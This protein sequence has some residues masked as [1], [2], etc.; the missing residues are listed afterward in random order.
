MAGSPQEARDGSG[1]GER[2]TDPGHWLRTVLYAS[3]CA[4]SGGGV[5]TDLFFGEA[6]YQSESGA[7]GGGARLRRRACI[8]SSS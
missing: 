5:G 7:G 4:R 8:G 2:G 3:L 6:D 1:G